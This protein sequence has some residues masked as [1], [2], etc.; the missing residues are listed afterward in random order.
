MLKVGGGRAAR[1][2]SASLIALVT[3]AAVSAFA[4]PAR[5]AAPG[6]PYGG[7][8]QGTVAHVSALDVMGT[9]VLNAE[10]GQASAAVASE[11]LPTAIYNEYDRPIV[12]AG[13]KGKNSY[14]R[15]SLLEAGLGVTKTDANQVAPFVS[16][17]ATSGGTK[18]DDKDPVHVPGSP[19][20]YLDALHTTA[21]ANW[22]ANTCVIGQPISAS[23]ATAASAQLVNLVSNTNPN[24]S[25]P[26]ALAGLGV[27]GTHS[28]EILYPG[29]GPGLGL[30]S[31][32]V[33]D[34]V[35]LALLQ[36]TANEVDIDV[37]PA[38]LVTQAD[39]TPGGAKVTY[40][41]PI[42]KISAGGQVIKILTDL[43]GPID[44][45]IP[46]G[47][48]TN[49]TDMLLRLKLGT[50]L[51]LVSSSGPN[52]KTLT[53]PDGTIAQGS[54]NVLE[55]TLLKVPEVPLTGATVSVGHLEAAAQVPSGGVSCPIP[56]TKTSDKES[57]TTG[58]SFTTT[59]KVDNPWVC[60]LVLSKVTDEINTIDGNATFQV[61][62]A[63]P[64]PSSPTLPTAD[65]LSSATVKWDKNLPTVPPGGSAIFTVTLKTGGGVENVIS[66]IRDIA[67]AEGA[68]SNCKPAPGSGETEVTGI[69]NVKVP[70]TGT[71]TF[72]QPTT[73]VLGVTKLPKTGVEDGAYS[74]A[75]IAMLLTAL[76]GGTVLRRRKFKIEQ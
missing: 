50:L 13:F 43:T 18:V 70:V 15:A 21:V 35:H 12:R 47:A 69:T 24:G 22:N 20:L 64:D 48:G 33:T 34:A 8:A 17:A 37:A 4:V 38:F 63:T 19:L 14:G 40:E 26:Q 7:F 73:K 71:G 6:G 41:A 11:G 36:G 59:I 54:V 61:T 3:G 5:A 1:K 52:I 2:F 39:G 49:G 67:T 32:T 53:K 28:Y 16:E 31:V 9:K 66:H 68:V 10:V 30:A 44:I 51:P 55:L 75:G 23:Q 72:T 45:Q 46:P 57:V 74:W 58:S 25:F 62:S 42:A 65:G 76:G 27:V 60:P 56:V 29:K